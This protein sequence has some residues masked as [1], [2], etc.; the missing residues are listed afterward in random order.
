MGQGPSFV[1]SPESFS[2][3]IFNPQPPLSRLPTAW[4]VAPSTAL[5]ARRRLLQTKPMSYQ[6]ENHLS[7]Q[8]PRPLYPPQSNRPIANYNHHHHHHNNTN[9]NSNN[10]SNNNN[11]IS[12]SLLSPGFS[13]LNPRISENTTTANAVGAVNMRRRPFFSHPQPHFGSP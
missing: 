13:R 11:N 3:N 6:K 1:S 9:S 7:V 4:S 2:R 10:N 8:S 5:A 12:S